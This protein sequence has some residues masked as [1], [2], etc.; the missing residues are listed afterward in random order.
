MTASE[1]PLV[2]LA[3]G[4]TGGHMF[5]AEALAAELIGRGCKIAL[6]T[7]KRGGSFGGHQADIETYRILASGLAGKSLVKRLR[8]VCELSC[9][10]LQAHF[11]LKRLAPRAVIGFGGYASIPTMLA[12][13]FGGFP[14]AIHEQN[15]V[16]GRANRLLASRVKRI[17]TTFKTP[18]NI[19]PDDE[20]KIFHTGMPVRASIVKMRETPYPALGD[21]GAI[22]ILVIGGSQG[23]HV[24]SEVMPKAVELLPEAIRSRLVIAQQCRPEDLEATRS[25]YKQLGMAPE[26]KPF[27]DDAPERLAAAHLIIGRAGASTVSEITV[28]GRPS[29]L[30][31]YPH[32]ID[33]HQSVNAHS[34]DEAGA[35]WLMPENSFNAKTL[36]A[37]LES[38]FNL[39]AILANTA[40]CALKAGRPDAAKR[41]ADMV[42]E[43]MSSGGGPESK[44]EAA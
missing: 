12:A 6:I 29:I 27:F 9:G 22:N 21:K 17:A 8:G 28:V 11:L 38:L 43:L 3:A 40:A 14:T 2:A 16:L 36:A 5:P 32:A 41:L 31:P 18:L 34:V 10:L 33:D 19:S 13:V 42:F 25:A 4:G 39:P 23:A 15:A 20:S 30:V 44:R 35:G 24:F 1:G 37:R 26:L 7:D